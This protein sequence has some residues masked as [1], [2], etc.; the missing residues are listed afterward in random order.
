[1]VKLAELTSKVLTAIFMYFLYS[2]PKT[3]NLLEKQHER[4]NYILVSWEMTT[5]IPNIISWSITCSILLRTWMSSLGPRQC[6]EGMN[7]Y[8]CIKIVL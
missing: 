7:K 6:N 3:T 5:L 1:M 2:S 4:S 8:N